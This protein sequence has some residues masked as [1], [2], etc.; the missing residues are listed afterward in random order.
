MGEM[1]KQKPVEEQVAEILCCY[2]D[3]DPEEIEDA[4]RAIIN[5]AIR[6]ARDQ[7]RHGHWD[8]DE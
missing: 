2:M 7:Y 3:G 1:M 8:E 4:I 6:E 5:A